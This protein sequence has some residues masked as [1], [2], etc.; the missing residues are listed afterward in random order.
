[1]RDLAADRAIDRRLGPLRVGRRPRARVHGCRGHQP[2]GPGRCVLMRLGD[3]R[4]PGNEQQ[5]GSADQ[6]GEHNE[7]A[8]IM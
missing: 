5:G 2:G 8:V 6:T 7:R 4:L 3:D 1:M